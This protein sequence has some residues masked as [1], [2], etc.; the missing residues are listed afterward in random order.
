MNRLLTILWESM[1]LDKDSVQYLLEFLGDWEIGGVKSN[2]FGFNFLSVFQ[3]CLFLMW[4]RRLTYFFLSIFWSLWHILQHHEKWFIID[5]DHLASFLHFANFRESFFFIFLLTCQT[6]N[7]WIMFRSISSRNAR[8]FMWRSVVTLRILKPY[9]FFILSSNSIKAFFSI[10]TEFITLP[11]LV[12]VK[13]II[14]F[15]CGSMK[16]YVPYLALKPG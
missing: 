15:D 10:T 16:V 1:F 3:G 4:K 7:C 8:I 5:L 14:L 13:S 6:S 9:V 11:T 2:L 12:S